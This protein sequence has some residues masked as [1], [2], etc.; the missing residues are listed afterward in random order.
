MDILLKQYV[1]GSLTIVFRRK[2]FES[3]IP[4]FN[5]QYHIIGDFDCVIR[6]AAYWKVS[7]V[8]EPV[9]H[10]R[11]L[12]ENDS[13]NNTEKIIQELNNYIDTTIEDKERSKSE[14]SNIDF[15]Y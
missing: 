1:V 8:Q 12:G 4:P 9:A 13:N 6:M 3:L 7:C 14:Q 5:P 10:Y 2:S 15:E 11:W